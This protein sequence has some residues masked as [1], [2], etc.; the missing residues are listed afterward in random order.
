MMVRLLAKEM[1][2]VRTAPMESSSD[3]MNHGGK[4]R[5]TKTIGRRPCRRPQP[6]S[7]CWRWICSNAGSG[8]HILIH[9]QLSQEELAMKRLALSFVLVITAL[10]GVSRSTGYADSTR[11]AVPQ[12]TPTTAPN[13]PN[14]NGID[15]MVAES[16]CDPGN[17]CG[18][19]TLSGGV[20]YD[21]ASVT[22]W[23]GPANQTASCV[24]RTNCSYVNYEGSGHYCKVYNGGNC[25]NYEFWYNFQMVK[26]NG[27]GVYNDGERIDFYTDGTDSAFHVTDC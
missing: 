18:N 20:Y 21:F 14:T 24:S 19:S 15:R 3:T 17:V 4:T 13:N 8:A 1:V 5:D 12:A 11:P 7:G 9:R 16:F 27:G 10:L 2:E 6:R 25:V 22:Y 26:L 23:Q